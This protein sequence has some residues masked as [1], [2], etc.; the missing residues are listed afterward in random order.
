MDEV[1]VD[2]TQITPTLPD[3]DSLEP[4]F[5]LHDTIV[6]IEKVEHLE[7]LPRCVVVL[8]YE[9][10]EDADRLQYL[11]QHIVGIT[12]AKLR[13]QDEEMMEQIHDLIGAFDTCQ[14][15]DQ[16]SC[17]PPFL[18]SFYDGEPREVLRSL[19]L[20]TVAEFA[21]AHRWLCER[22]ELLRDL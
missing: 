17:G 13:V 4:R 19:E 11:A 5:Q 3:T 12:F 18:V 20:R 7:R 2:E 22:K 16:N 6:V 1:E 21:L 15:N 14:R 8:I 9:E 10:I